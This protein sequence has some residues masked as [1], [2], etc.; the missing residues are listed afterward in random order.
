MKR[1]D[2]LV[3]KEKYSHINRFLLDVLD[4]QASKAVRG[5]LI[6]EVYDFLALLDGVKLVFLHGRGH[7]P[8]QW[9]EPIKTFACSLK[10]FV[11]EGFYWDATPYDEFPNWYQD[12]CRNKLLQFRAWYIC[13]EAELA[14]AIKNINTRAG[15]LSMAEEAYLLGYPECCVRAHYE[16]ACRYHRGTLSILRRLAKGDQNQM[17]ALAIG[18]AH[19]TPVT[20]QEIED[21]D[22]AFKLHTPRVGS[23]NM[24]ESCS[25]G[26]KPFG[27]LCLA[28]S[29]V[30]NFS[31]SSYF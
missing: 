24:C 12:H 11:I 26:A 3:M 13:K 25:S 27:S 19:L 7:A 30:S 10:L 31:R 4:Q 8:V 9:V 2:G 17:K 22:F 6:G 1:L 16:R 20:Q 23:W 5:E 15:R 28:R 18:N 21:F 29:K 14:A